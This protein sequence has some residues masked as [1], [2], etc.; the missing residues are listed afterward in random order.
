MPRVP[1]ACLQAVRWRGELAEMALFIF[2]LP[3]ALASGATACAAKLHTLRMLGQP[4][5]KFG[6]V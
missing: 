5:T 2:R 3:L 4:E 6:G 1:T